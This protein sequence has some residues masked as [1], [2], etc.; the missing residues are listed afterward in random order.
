MGGDRETVI[1]ASKT[2]A[3][4]SST[5]L[6]DLRVHESSGEVHVHNDK[7]GLKF[8][9]ASADFFRAWEEGKN[10]SF[11]P[12]L[13]LLGHDGKGGNALLYIERT[14]AGPETVEIAMSIAPVKTGSSF[15]AVE[16]FITGA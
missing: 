11:M 14:A 3:R 7:A 16:K 15:K 2:S 13:H 10:R 5:V 1:P 8:A 12:S 4:P 6:G 9:M